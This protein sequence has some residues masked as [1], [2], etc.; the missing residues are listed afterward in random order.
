M[1]GGRKAAH[2]PVIDHPRH[3]FYADTFDTID[4]RHWLYSSRNPER[5]F[6]VVSLLDNS[7]NEVADPEIAAGG[8]VKLGEESFTTFMF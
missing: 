2:R 7:A 8:V 5:R 1:G 3:D 6:E 4:G